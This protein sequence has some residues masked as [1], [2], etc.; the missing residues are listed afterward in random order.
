VRKAPSIDKR[1]IQRGLWCYVKKLG[2]PVIARA[3][4]GSLRLEDHVFRCFVRSGG[5]AGLHGIFLKWAL[6]IFE[7]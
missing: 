2:N 7:D 4:D 1:Q 3:P 5:K 6:I